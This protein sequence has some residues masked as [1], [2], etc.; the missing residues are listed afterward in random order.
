M[1]DL[2]ITDEQI[3][4][5]MVTALEGGINYWCGKTEMK[6]D[7][8][9]I[10]FDGVTLAD[11]EE[12]VYGSDLIAKGGTLILHDAESSDKWELNKE[13]FMVGL[14]KVMEWGE[15]ESIEELMDEHDA[16]TADVLIQFAIF[17]EIVFG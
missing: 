3:S 2:K 9:G 15:F 17:N 11:D 5:L 13:K 7:V 12:V 6:K 8:L 16:E 10:G 4:D 14:E 1:K